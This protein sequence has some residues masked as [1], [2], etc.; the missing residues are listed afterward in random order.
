MR[1]FQ[2]SQNVCC[3]KVPCHSDG[4]HVL[5]FMDECLHFIS[6]P[7]RLKSLGQ[8]PVLEVHA[9]A[10]IGRTPP[11]CSIKDIW[12]RETSKQRWFMASGREDSINVVFK[13]QIF[14]KLVIARGGCYTNY[15]L[16]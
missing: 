9:T 5:L 4:N 8:V 1:L 3:E 12:G 2:T 11:P 16:C 15:T 7:T 10:V 6:V 14:I 13:L